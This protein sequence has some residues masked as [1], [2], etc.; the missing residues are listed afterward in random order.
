M[1]VI[2][3]SAESPHNNVALEQNSPLEGDRHRKGIKRGNKC[4]N[5]EYFYVIYRLYC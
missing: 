3:E 5:L 4:T 1:K 2:D